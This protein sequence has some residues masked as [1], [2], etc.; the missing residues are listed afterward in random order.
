LRGNE[1]ARLA[2]LQTF[3]QQPRGQH[4]GLEYSLSGVRQRLVTRTLEKLR[5]TETHS[6]SQIK[7]AVKYAFDDFVQAESVFKRINIM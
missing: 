4:F 5:G 7:K 1:V 6:M 2:I 3:P